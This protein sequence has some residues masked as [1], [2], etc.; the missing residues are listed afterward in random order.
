MSTEYGNIPAFKKHGVTFPSAKIRYHYPD[1]IERQQA[2]ITAALADSTITGNERKA[3]LSAQ[4]QWSRVA[5]HDGRTAADRPERAPRAPRA[6]NQ[7]PA[8]NMVTRTDATWT[9][10]IA[11]W[12]A[13]Y[14]ID[15]PQRGAS[16]ADRA[17]ARQTLTILAADGAAL[18][19]PQQAALA[20]LRAAWERPTTWG[21]RLGVTPLR[22]LVEQGVVLR[23]DAGRVTAS[24]DA[25]AARTDIEDVIAAAA[26]CDAPVDTR[27][28]PPTYA[29]HAADLAQLRQWMGAWNAIGRR[30]DQ[31]FGGA[32]VK[33]SR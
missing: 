14:R 10:E 27:E 22:T 26:D 17:L 25:S 19:P 24:A 8:T 12:L 32:R 28:E 4:E 29:L 16:D 20:R 1:H 9:P 31:D 21:D 2:A 6:V 11:A 5:V 23:P 30:A 13:A 7:R 33:G 3:L 18:T 15:M